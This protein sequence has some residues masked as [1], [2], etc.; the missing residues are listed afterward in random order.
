MMLGKMIRK[1]RLQH[2]LTLVDLAKKM[3]VR[4]N[5]VERWEK[6]RVIPR[7]STIF[8]IERVFSLNPGCLL[9]ILDLEDNSEKKVFI[10][11]APNNDKNK[12]EICR[13]IVKKYPTYVVF[14]PHN[15]ASFYPKEWDKC[16]IFQQHHPHLLCLSDELWT[17]GACQSFNECQWEIDFAERCGV[18]IIHEPL[19]F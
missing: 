9:S 6:S 12:D 8:R 3:D 14:S 7:I 15:E 1:Y 13:A 10:V 4:R 5:T 11:V 18:K 2:G 16:A 17:F 19:L